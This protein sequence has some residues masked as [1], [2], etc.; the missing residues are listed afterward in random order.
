MEFLMIILFTV[1][2]F[3][4]RIGR[5]PIK[6]GKNPEQNENQEIGKLKND[7]KRDQQNLKNN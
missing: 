3:V 6:H 5:M 4:E 1:I 7:I 2:L